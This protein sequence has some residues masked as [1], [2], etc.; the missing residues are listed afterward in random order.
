MDLLLS[1]SMIGANEFGNMM[2][3]DDPLVNDCLMSM[4]FYMMFDSNYEKKKEEKFQEFSEKFEKLNDEQKEIVK[5]DYLNIIEAQDKVRE[6][7]KRKGD[8]YE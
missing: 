6:K 3:I 7:V 1:M 2:Y 4:Y 5:Q 8:K